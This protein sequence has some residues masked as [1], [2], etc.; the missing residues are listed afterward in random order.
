MKRNFVDGRTSICD[1]EPSSLSI[2]KVKNLDNGRK[3]DSAINVF[4]YMM[5]KCDPFVNMDK[6]MNSL[7]NMSEEQK[8]Q[9]INDLKKMYFGLYNENKDRIENYK[10]GNFEIVEESMEKYKEIER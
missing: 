3:D 1:V 5:S 10:K 9:K 6:L 7:Q 8:Y 2:L 4:L